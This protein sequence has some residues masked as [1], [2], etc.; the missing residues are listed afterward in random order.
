MKYEISHHEALPVPH[1]TYRICPLAPY[2]THHTYHTYPI[3]CLCLAIPNPYQHVSTHTTAQHE[4]NPRKSTIKKA[5]EW[6]EWKETSHYKSLLSLLSAVLVENSRSY[7]QS[8]NRSESVWSVCLSVTPNRLFFLSFAL[9][10]LS[11]AFAN[12]YNSIAFDTQ[13]AIAV[14]T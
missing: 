11:L 14:L 10:A 1:F 4:H 8:F 13:N 5:T 3:L 7:T 2:Q 12:M 9:E 6:N